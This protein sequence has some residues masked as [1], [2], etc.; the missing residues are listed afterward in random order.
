MAADAISV[1]SAQQSALA[2]QIGIAVQK[3]QLDAIKQQ[4]AAMV[5]LL[6][7]AAQLSKSPT[8]GASYDAVG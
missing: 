6:Q 4:G 7:A 5:E 2:A 3:K 1:P 8:T